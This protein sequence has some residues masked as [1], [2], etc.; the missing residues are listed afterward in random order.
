MASNVLAD[1]RQQRN[2]IQT[3]NY[4]QQMAVEQY[5]K[6]LFGVELD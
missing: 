4:T 6:L 2:L 1:A 5:R 3:M